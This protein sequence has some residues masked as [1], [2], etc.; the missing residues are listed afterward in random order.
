MARQKRVEITEAPAERDLS[1][2]PESVTAHFA[3][4]GMHAS[5]ASSH[6]N[7]VAQSANRQQYALTIEDLPEDVEVRKALLGDLRVFGFRQTPDGMI[8]RGDCYLYIQSEDSREAYFQEGREQWNRQNSLDAAMNQ[9]AE[10]QGMIPGGKGSARLIDGVGP[11][12][13]HVNPTL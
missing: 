13:S 4:V 3:A 9:A 2:I 11:L 10:I 6:E 5:L 1:S 7:V 8:K 12:T